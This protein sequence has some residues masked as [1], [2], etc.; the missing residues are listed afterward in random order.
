MDARLRLIGLQVRLERGDQ[1]HG[2]EIE[3]PQIENHL[4]RLF[5]R[6]LELRFCIAQKVERTG[7]IGKNKAPAQI[8]LEIDAD[9]RLNQAVMD[10]ARDPTPFFGH[11]RSGFL[12][13]E[14]IQ[15]LVFF[16]IPLDIHVGSDARL[17]ELPHELGTRAADD[18]NPD[19]IEFRK[20]FLHL[21]V[22]GDINDEIHLFRIQQVAVV[23]SDG[24]AI[25][26]GESK[27][28]SL[29]IDFGDADDL[30]Q[31]VGR[32]DGQQRGPALSGADQCH[33]RDRRRGPRNGATPAPCAKAAG[34]GLSLGHGCHAPV[35][36]RNRS[37]R[38]EHDGRVYRS[39]GLWPRSRT[40]SFTSSM[41]CSTSLNSR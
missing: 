13:I 27:A 39:G 41:N 40:N 23:S 6:G 4:P 1:P 25:A 24:N 7:R 21:S 26:L 11:R 10:V 32:K 38:D 12:D 17:D 22:S 20:G 18:R 9:E 3:R 2:L 36:K 15:V 35:T 29:R 31:W 28:G 8:Q 37:R 16:E 14:F 19:A 34:R 33:A 30:H 5:D